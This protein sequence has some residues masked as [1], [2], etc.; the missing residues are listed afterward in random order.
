MRENFV[1]IVSIILFAGCRDI[2]YQE[3]EP[4]LVLE[5]SVAKNILHETK[6][7]SQPVEAAEPEIPVIER[8]SS[9]RKSGGSR[10]RRNESKPFIDNKEPILPEPNIPIDTEAPKIIGAN[11]GMIQPSYLQETIHYR[12]KFIGDEK[13]SR[14]FCLR[15]YQERSGCRKSCRRSFQLH[16]GMIMMWGGDRC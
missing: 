9:S 16:G 2:P 7:I 8:E 14:L 11:D 12:Q 3:Q 1:L 5:E 10:N 4:K 6:S 13:N 15:S